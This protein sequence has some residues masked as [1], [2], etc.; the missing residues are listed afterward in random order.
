MKAFGVNSALPKSS[1]RSTRN[2]ERVGVLR[3]V[4]ILL[5]VLQQFFPQFARTAPSQFVTQQ[6]VPSEIDIVSSIIEVKVLFT[7]SSLFSIHDA[8]IRLGLPSI[9]PQTI[10][11]GVSGL[12]AKIGPLD[13]DL[14]SLLEYYTVQGKKAVQWKMRLNKAVHQEALSRAGQVTWLNTA[15]W[16]YDGKKEYLFRLPEVVSI[17]HVIDEPVVTDKCDSFARLCLQ[18]KRSRSRTALTRSP[19]AS[20]KP[21][22][23]RSLDTY[24]SVWIRMRKGI[25]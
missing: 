16:G 18:V 9:S 24:S 6:Q 20:S 21:F 15:G 17:E 11:S 4:V 1:T 12:A 10:S 13:A 5:L 2:A 7:M 22:Q 23:P 25:G 19:R 14:P 3:S 8:N